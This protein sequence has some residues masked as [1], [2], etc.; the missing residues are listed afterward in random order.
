MVCWQKSKLT[1]QVI[2]P[3]NC[4]HHGA[5]NI[6]AQN[7]TCDTTVRLFYQ[8]STT[9][10]PGNSD[11][12]TLIVTLHTVFDKLVWGLP[13]IS[14]V[15]LACGAFFLFIVLPVTAYCCCRKPTNT[16][17]RKSISRVRNNKLSEQLQQAASW[18]V[19]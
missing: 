18:F 5:C 17:G 12:T 14:L 9:C 4:N 11:W 7:C 16:A 8:N 1:T 6:D 13:I 3:E 15:S 2:C 19:R 10:L